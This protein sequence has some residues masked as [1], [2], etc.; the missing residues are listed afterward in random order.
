VDGF[1][2]SGNGR[3]ELRRCAVRTF[4]QSEAW[5][6]WTRPDAAIDLDGGSLLV[7]ST[8][9]ACEAT[10][11]G[12]RTQYAIMT[13][14][15]AQAQVTGSQFSGFRAPIRWEINSDLKGIASNQI[16]SGNEYDA[17]VS[18]GGVQTRNVTA[19]QLPLRLFSQSVRPVEH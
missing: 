16:F 10:S 14:P 11:G 6:D 13:A 15:G 4:E 12:Q 7:E 19:T 17:V 3:L 2:V 5:T 1:V 8:Q 9:F 18:H